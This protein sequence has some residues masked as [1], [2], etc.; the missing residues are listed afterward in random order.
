MKSLCGVKLKIL[1][2]SSRVP[3]SGAKGDQVLAFNRLSYLS[4]QHEIQLICF[5]HSPADK[6]AVQELER[7]GIVVHCVSWSIQYAALNLFRAMFNPK[8]PFQ[9]ALFVSPKFKSILNSVLDRFH[10][11]IIH[12]ITIRVLENLDRNDVPLVIDMVDSMALNFSRRVD[13]SMGLRR[14]FY[15]HEYNRVNIYEKAAVEEARCSFV[16]SNVDRVTVN[17]DRVDVI[18][19]GVDLETFKP[20]KGYN[21]G[22]AIVFTGNMNYQPNIDA[23]M[24]FYHYCWSNLKNKLP[25]I[26]WI[27]AGGG[28]THQVASLGEKDGITITGRVASLA[29]VINRSFLSI[30]P[31]RSGSGMQF[32]ILEAMACAVPVVAS[33]MGLGDI[34]AVTDQDIILADTPDAFV[35]AIVDMWEDEGKRNMIAANGLQYVRKHHSWNSLNACFEERL[36]GLL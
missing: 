15:K 16:V 8:L 4:R 29:D 31:M 6:L 10:P 34:K 1:T 17:Y 25:E 32:K 5:T 33:S 22:S 9:C 35:A 3:A 23:V 2:I 11:D 14:I 19:L 12:S 7:L 36:L 27:I 21:H 30:A 20:D 26:Q 13:K 28:V 24:W 18:P